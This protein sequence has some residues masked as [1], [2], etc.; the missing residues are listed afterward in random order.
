MCFQGCHYVKFF[1][2]S[3]LF[4]PRSGV[5][6][7]C[8]TFHWWV[9][10]V[11]ADADLYWVL[12]RCFACGG[13]GHLVKDC[14]LTQGPYRRICNLLDDPHG[15]WSELLSPL[16]RKLIF[17]LL[18]WDSQSPDPP[19]AAPW[20]TT[21]WGDQGTWYQGG[22][23]WASIPIPPGPYMTYTSFQAQN[24]QSWSL[25]DWSFPPL[26]QSLRTPCIQQQS[27]SHRLTRQSSLALFPHLMTRALL[28]LSRIFERLPWK[29]GSG[30]G[31]STQC[32]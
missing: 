13:T 7:S 24:P 3:S 25:L 8:N 12:E 9:Q 30:V 21:P 27:T 2:S 17:P 31:S 5:K 26:F 29:L 23:N 10:L 11:P 16:S 4:A 28:V 6:L 32:P 20:A 19:I 18:A 22:M 15:E 14:S 1:S